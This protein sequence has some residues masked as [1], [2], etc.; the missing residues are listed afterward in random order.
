MLYNSRQ[1]APIDTVQSTSK[2]LN[3]IL[4]YFIDYGTVIIRTYTGSIVMKRMTHPDHFLYYVNGL[5]SRVSDI[6]RQTAAEAM[7]IVIRRR[8]GIPESK[9]PLASGGGAVKPAVSR[10][11]S[12]V[13]LFKIRIEQGT[14][15]TYR[16]HWFVLLR[17]IWFQTLA[18]VGLFVLAFSMIPSGVFFSPFFVI[19]WCLGLAILMAWWV[20]RY[21]DWSNDIYIL[22]PENVMDID[23]KPFTTEEKRVAPLANILSLENER[24]GF[25]GNLL[26]FGT[27]TVNVGQEKLTFDEIPSPA[28]VQYEI[29]DRMTAFKQRKAEDEANKER[30]RMAD[31]LAAY[32]RQVEILEN[33]E[34][35]STSD[36]L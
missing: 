21:L 12:L 19:P 14:T 1:E 17:Q 9:G 8:L 18:V 22:T 16:K 35:S 36:E 34:R 25:M 15:V 30:E 5:K 29:F 13:N 20:Y 26:N 32:H 28:R 2:K 4:R 3:Q 23:R 33:L 11:R 31:W 6:A 24:L 10:R 27:V 7:D